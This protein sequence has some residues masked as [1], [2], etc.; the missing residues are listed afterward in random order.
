MILTGPNGPL[1][2]IILKNVGSLLS[3]N[4]ST[5]TDVIENNSEG[6]MI[7]IEAEHKYSAAQNLN[8]SAE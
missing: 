3:F 5:M 8:P 4:M 2:S 6:R 7:N 1:L